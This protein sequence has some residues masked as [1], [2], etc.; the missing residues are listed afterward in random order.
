MAKGPTITEGNG[1]PMSQ[2]KKPI[3]RP[4]PPPSN[5]GFQGISGIPS[6]PESRP[7]TMRNLSPWKGFNPGKKS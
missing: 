6:I 7:T 2:V 4:T 5:T 1:I 3:M